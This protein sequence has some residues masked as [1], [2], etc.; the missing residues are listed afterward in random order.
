MATSLLGP[1][2]TGAHRNSRSD[3]D[4]SSYWEHKASTLALA[5][6]MTKEPAIRTKEIEPKL[7]CILAA[8][9]S[10]VR[11]RVEFYRAVDSVPASNVAPVRRHRR[12]S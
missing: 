6:L 11:T 7:D 5:M 4:N 12:A 1:M 9:N 10:G 8:L 3:T 2:L